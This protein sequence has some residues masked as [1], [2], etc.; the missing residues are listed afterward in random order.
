MTPDVRLLAYAAV[1]CWVMIMTAAMLKTRG[2]VNAG[3]NRDD[4][5]EPSAA[6]GR[7]DRAAKNMLEN[8]VLFTA[9]LAA[10]RMGNGDQDRIV[11]GAR[12]F[13]WAR[14]AY[15]PVYLAGIKHIRTAIWA[16]GI[17]G[18]AIIFSAIL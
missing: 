13:F 17:A 5:P 10:A 11:L 14:V 4:L 6:A 15:F 7:A 9:L 8:L 18:L 12:I 2:L 3:G 16:V 1:L